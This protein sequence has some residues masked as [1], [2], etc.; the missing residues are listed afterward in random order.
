MNRLVFQAHCEN[1][2]NFDKT[3]DLDIY[4]HIHC[5]YIHTLHS[6]TLCCSSTHQIT[7]EGLVELEERTSTNED[8]PVSSLRRLA[9]ERRGGERDRGE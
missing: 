8:H 1:V 9:K 6:A 5:T 2:L 4:T 3:L 7:I